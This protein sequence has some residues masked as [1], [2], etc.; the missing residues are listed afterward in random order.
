MTGGS[1]LQAGAP[2]PVVNAR[3]DHLREPL[4]LVIDVEHRLAKA[5]VKPDVRIL[6]YELGDRL[7]GVVGRQRRWG[8]EL[9]FQLVTLRQRRR[10]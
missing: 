4:D 10:Q 5:D 3:Q 6:S 7:S 9:R 8:G 1:F 2:H